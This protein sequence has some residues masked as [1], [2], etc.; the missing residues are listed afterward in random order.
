METTLKKIAYAFQR[1]RIHWGIGG[2]YLLK[3][4]GIASSANDVDIVIAPE[5]MDKALEILDFWGE[6]RETKTD[7]NY[8]TAR[9]IAYDIEGTHVDVMSD[10]KVR[11]NEELYH[12]EF[13]SE[14]VWYQDRKDGV[15]YPYMRLE[16]WYVL[17]Y[18]MKREQRL[19]ALD[20]YIESAQRFDL[21]RIDMLTS[22][23]QY[24]N[25][26][27]LRLNQSV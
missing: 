15:K 9:Y 1:A 7:P 23:S 5:S 4:H 11:F 16:D 13:D 3:K 22:K 2:S 26:L 20:M 19:E 6:R 10:I 14:S 18:F 27:M 17:Y 24:K 8:E 12:Y 25:E 21:S